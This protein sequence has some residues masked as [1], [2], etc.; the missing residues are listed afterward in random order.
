MGTLGGTIAPAHGSAD[1]AGIPRKTGG[2]ERLTTFNVRNYGAVGDGITDDTAAIHAA[3]DAAGV[4]G[5]V[6]FPP[7]T[8]LTTGLSATI[9]SQ[10]WQIMAGATVKSKGSGSTGGPITVDAAHVMITGGGAVDGNRSVIG[11]NAHV[12]SCITGTVNASDLTVDNIA[13]QNAVFYGVWGQA[14]RTRVLRCRFFGNYTTPIMLSS[15]Y[16]AVLLGSTMQDTYDMEASGN[17]ID[18]RDEDP[19]TL[20]STAISIRGN[21]DNSGPLHNTYRGKALRNT[22]L[23]PVNP[24]EPTGIVCGIEFGAQSYYGLAEGNRIENGSMGISFARGDCGKAVGNTFIGQSLFAIEMADSPGCVIQGNVINGSGRLGSLPSGSAITTQGAAGLSTDISII[25]NHIYGIHDSGRSI[26][27]SHSRYTVTGNTVE[28]KYGITLSN[29]SDANVSNNLI[30]GNGTGQG[31]QLVKCNRIVMSGNTVQS[32][33]VGVQIS[34]S[35]ATAGV[36][37]ISNN[38][39]WDCNV[40]V[41][42]VAMS[43]NA[44]AQVITKDG[45]IIGPP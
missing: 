12:W 45:N 21:N 17:Y 25:G 1:S 23:M 38:R 2:P 13:V 6:V 35:S 33:N 20:A 31:V 5:S 42:E 27:L 18:R 19:A 14:S 37:N 22:I 34:A 15:Y 36:F 11:G 10:V 16:L 30:R 44:V 9:V 3:R 32:Q 43:S 40:P 24:A 8:Y 26:S 41:D 39:F 7:G 29:V 28:S 4:G